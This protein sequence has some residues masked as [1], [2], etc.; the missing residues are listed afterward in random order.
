MEAFGGGLFGIGEGT[1]VEFEMTSAVDAEEADFDR[2]FNA[3]FVVGVN[4]LDVQW[5]RLAIDATHGF[6]VVA[7][8]AIGISAGGA[9]GE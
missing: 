2:D 7:F 1:G 9:S 6:V 4:G 8:G 5:H 3:V